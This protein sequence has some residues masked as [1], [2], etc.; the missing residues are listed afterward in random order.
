[1]RPGAKV[2]LGFCL[3]GLVL[4]PLPGRPQKTPEELHK[5]TLE[6]CAASA[7]T[8]PG[9]AMVQEKVDQACNLLEKEG[10]A[11]FPKFTGKNSDFIFCG[12]YIWAH[13]LKGVMRLD[14]AIPQMEGMNLSD[15]K[16]S[17]NKRPFA[18]MNRVAKEKGAGWVDYWWP[19]PGSTT[20]SR[21]VSYVK[22]CKVD[23]E[24]LVVGAGIYDLPGAEID[25]FLLAQETSKEL[26][27]ETEAAV[28]QS[29]VTNATSDLV[30]EK[31]NA[32]CALLEREG[33]AAFPKFKGKQSKFIFAG[34]YIWIQDLNGVMRMHPTRADWEGKVTLDWKDSKGKPIFAEFNKMAQ[35]KGAGWVDYWWA[36]PGEQNPSH[37]VSYV[38][39]CKID[40]EDLV[41][42]STI[43]GLPDAEIEKLIK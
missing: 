14:P 10:K 25:K 8:R 13:D 43:D 21:I 23:G 33:R 42:G 9:F 19:K 3:A 40:G 35:T 16:D 5:E 2:L 41:V 11:A 15:V 18:E 20:P 12:T 6:A 17:H 32:A 27:A 38:K 29:A 4:R 28:A 1:M 36:K 7:K 39:L 22:L 37:Q 26:A 34:T 24:D 31:V 30:I